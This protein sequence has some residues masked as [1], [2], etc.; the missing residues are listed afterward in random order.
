MNF[1]PAQVSWEDG[2]LRATHP[3]F[4]VSTAGSNLA[5][6]LPEGSSCWIGIRPED[7]SIEVGGDEGLATTVYVTE[8][9]GGE[10]VVDVNLHDSLVKALAPPTLSL[11]VNQPVR[12]RL[13]VKRLHLFDEEGA[14]VVSAAGEERFELTTASPR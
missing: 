11:A 10:T 2:S 13:D 5:R 7:V 4:S 3:L 14:A 1:I 6:D 8:P 9:L 12:A